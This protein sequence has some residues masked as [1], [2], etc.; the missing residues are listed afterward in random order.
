MQPEGSFFWRGGSSCKFTDHLFGPSNFWLVFT[1]NFN[2]ISCPAYVHTH[3]LQPA[4]NVE[5][6]SLILREG[7]GDSGGSQRRCCRQEPVERRTDG[8]YWES[9]GHQER[10]TGFT[11]MEGRDMKFNW[12]KITNQS[13]FVSSA[14]LRRAYLH[15]RSMLEIKI[16]QELFLKVW[17]AKFCSKLDG[18]LAVFF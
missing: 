14:T 6:S 8:K 17:N 9:W 10:W 1:Y 3:H 18:G 12:R 13:G 2:L 5:E 11:G 7:Q 16:Y 15:P 4:K